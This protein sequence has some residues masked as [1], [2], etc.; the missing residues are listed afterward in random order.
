MTILYPALP[1]ATLPWR[2]RPVSDSCL[3]L[4]VH[5]AERAD[6]LADALTTILLEPPEDPFAPEIVAVPTRGMERWLSQRLSG[7]LGATDTQLD[8][9]CA[10]V[11]FPPPRRLIG[12]ALAAASGAEPREDPWLPER[13]LWPLL[14]VV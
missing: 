4:H 11:L 1:C 5:R 6:A 7:R 14:D 9:V 2:L 10:N 13:A 12:D 8:G 3:V